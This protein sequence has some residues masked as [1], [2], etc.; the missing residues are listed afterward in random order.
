MFRSFL[1]L[2]TGKTGEQKTKGR[3]LS[4]AE[5]FRLAII[6]IVLINLFILIIRRAPFALYSNSPISPMLNSPH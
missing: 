4:A 2:R 3:N 5:N 1:C 6:P